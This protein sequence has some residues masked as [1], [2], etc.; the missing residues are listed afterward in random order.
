MGPS[1]PPK[2]GPLN[3]APCCTLIIHSFIE[4]VCV[5]SLSK[6]YDPPHKIQQK[7]IKLLIS[8]TKTKMMTIWTHVKKKKAKFLKQLF[9]EPCFDGSLTLLPCQKFQAQVGGPV[10]VPMGTGVG[11][12]ARGR[13]CSERRLYSE[14]V[15]GRCPQALWPPPPKRVGRTAELVGCSLG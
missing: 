14:P 10:G 3:E 12:D 15:W 5:E 13:N 9:S 2:G 7:N 4:H 6:S 8:V 11:A 1:P